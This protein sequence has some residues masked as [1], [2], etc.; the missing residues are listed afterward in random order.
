MQTLNISTRFLSNDK[1]ISWENYSLTIKYKGHENRLL[2][3][4]DDAFTEEDLV[5]FS[6]VCLQHL[7]LKSFPRSN[8]NTLGDLWL[9]PTD[10][11]PTLTTTREFLCTTKQRKGK[12]LFV[13]LKAKSFQ[14]YSKRKL[15]L[16]Y[17]VMGHTTTK[18]HPN[19]GFL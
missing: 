19:R 16:T 5:F 7:P 1:R 8:D 4:K 6:T 10:F 9:I 3:R 17:P 13:I 15:R 2:G 14:R 11:P 12:R 18:A